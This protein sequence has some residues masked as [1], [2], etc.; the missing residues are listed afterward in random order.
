MKIEALDYGLAGL[1]LE[2]AESRGYGNLKILIPLN[3]ED[4]SALAMGYLVWVGGKN[5]RCFACRLY[6]PS[7]M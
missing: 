3:V 5:V 6:N 1:Y 2:V 4:Q 7:R